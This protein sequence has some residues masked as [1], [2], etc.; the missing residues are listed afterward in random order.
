MPV[1]IGSLPYELLSAILEQATELNIKQQP[2]YTYGLSQAPEPLQDASIQCVVRGHLSPD[3]LKWNATNSIRRVNR[4][5]HGWASEY[6]FDSLYITRWRGSERSDQ[7]LLSLRDQLLNSLSRRWI[8]SRNLDALP[9]FIKPTSIAVYRDPYHSLTESDTLFQSNPA[10]A[11]CIRRIWFDGYY[12]AETIAILFNILYHCN[13]LDYLTVPWTAMRYGNEDDWSRLLGRNNKGQSISSLEF[14]AVDL[15]QTQILK[16]AK[17][18]DRK[19][20]QSSKVSFSG[21]RRLKIFGHSNFLPLTDDDLFVIANTAVN[22]R[23]IHITGTVSVTIDGIEALVDSSDQTLEVLEHSPLIA[24]GFGHLDPVNIH[25]HKHHF[26]RKI[27]RCPRLRNLSL[28]LPS[29]CEELFASTSVRWR[30][31]M[32]IR[33]SIVCGRH[34]LSLKISPEAQSQFWRVLDQAR[35]LMFFRQA[36]GVELDIEIFVG[37][38]IFEPRHFLVHG[39]LALGEAFSN[40]TWPPDKGPSGKGPH[41]QT[42]LYGK[43]EG[44]YE[45]ISEE[46]FKVGLSSHYVAFII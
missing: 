44:P 32:Q 8:Q 4:A 25:G 33:T 24:D 21:L 1:T 2:Q 15:K 14:L 45:S 42:G 34:P 31:E 46:N 39:S 41:G 26:C 29:L 13:N 11:S 9:V 20:L 28:S 10:L 22:L 23:E 36:E 5:W 27:L 6:A 43:D 37:D 19:P 40:G 35:K 12:G 3:T 16:I 38:W 30:G 17:Q 7:G 18:I